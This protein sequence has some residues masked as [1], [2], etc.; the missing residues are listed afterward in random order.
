M[1]V[2]CAYLRNKRMGGTRNQEKHSGK[3]VQG[4]KMQIQHITNNK[5]HQSINQQK[6]QYFPHNTVFCF[7]IEK[8]CTKQRRNRLQYTIYCVGTKQDATFVV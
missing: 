6:Q 8:L 2:Y 4:T 5:H 1:C 7:E 3:R